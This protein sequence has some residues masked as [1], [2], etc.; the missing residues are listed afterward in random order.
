[1]R[2]KNKLAGSVAIPRSLKV[3][4]SLMVFASYSWLMYA[5][6][7][8]PGHPFV[9]I[10][11]GIWAAT[12]PTAYRTF[13][14]PDATSTILTSASLVGIS[15]G[16]TGASATS[17]ALNSFTGLATKGDLLVHDGSIH[18]RFIL[19]SNNTVLTAQS[20]QVLGVT[21][22]GVSVPV[23]GITGNL[24]YN[25]VL[26][27]GGTSSLS[28]STTTLGLGVSGS[29]LFSTTSTTLNPATTSLRVYATGVA[30]LPLLTT[31]LHS[32]STSMYTPAFF[33]RNIVSIGTA[34]AT[35]LSVI[36]NSASSTGTI[37]H[38][39]S[40]P[41]G[42]MADFSANTG[43]S[44]T[45]GVFASTSQFMRGTQVGSNGFFFRLRAAFVTAT[46]SGYILFVGMTSGAGMATVGH[47]NPAGSHIGFQFS[48]QRNDR[49][50]I[51]MAKDGTTQLLASTSIQFSL[52]TP[53]NFYLYSPAFPNNAVLYYR[54]EN[55]LTRAFFEGSATTSLPAGGTLLRP[56][57]ASG[58]TNVTAAR[59]I[60]L[61]GM[62]VQSDN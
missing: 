52:N 55:V 33:S 28:F 10:G 62:Y 41:M 12:G 9:Q 50:W 11:D 25:D 22:A 4:V 35:T 17:T 21:W 29:L 49:N 26:F 46:S 54:I 44:S 48:T 14:F 58:N 37:S 38:V 47:L 30:G 18:G 27:F 56:G 1:M 8:S 19:G 36:G 32:S 31:R 3:V 60:R 45:A 23:G 5:A 13:T 57:F 43:A 2:N 39:I 6:T 40:E 53:Y 61:G 24:Q 59:N 51:F 16:G 20:A 7:P 15:G 34:A 42:Y